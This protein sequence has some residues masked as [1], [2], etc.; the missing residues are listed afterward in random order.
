[1]TDQVLKPLLTSREVADVLRVDIRTVE[2]MVAAGAI[3]SLLVG[4]SRRF[5]QDAIRRWLDEAAA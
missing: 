3:P 2:R 5:D 4:G 1:M